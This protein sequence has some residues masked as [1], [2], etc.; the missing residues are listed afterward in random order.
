M[1]FIAAKTPKAGP[2]TQIS[3][4]PAERVT[5]DLPRHIVKA[6]MAR[7]WS[8]EIPELPYA[9]IATPLMI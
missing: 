5:P 8:R 2:L 7:T 1:R 6:F 4:P 3:P 9:P